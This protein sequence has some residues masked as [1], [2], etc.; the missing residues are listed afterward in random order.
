LVWKE[1]ADLFTLSKCII[2]I[3]EKFENTKGVIRDRQSK[4]DTDKYNR[5]EKKDKRTNNDLHN[6][7]QKTKD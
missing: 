4:K 6:N 7:T 1:L 3:Y 2:I 5:P